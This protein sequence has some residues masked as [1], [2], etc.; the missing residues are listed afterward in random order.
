MRLWN[1]LTWDAV[2][3]NFYVAQIGLDGYLERNSV[4]DCLIQ[5][6]YFQ[7]RKHLTC[8]LLEPGIASFYVFPIHPLFPHYPLL[9]TG[10]KGIPDYMSL[11]F[12]PARH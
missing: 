12:S 11:A 4:E 10:R 9:A 3:A 1:S 6:Q 2:D 5:G 7:P 8:H